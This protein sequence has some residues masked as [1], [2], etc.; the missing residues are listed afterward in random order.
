MNHPADLTARRVR[1][2]TRTIPVMMTMEVDTAKLHHLA[3]WIQPIFQTGNGG[4]LQ[5]ERLTIPSMTETQL[6]MASQS[7]RRNLWRRKW[8]WSGL[9][10]L[11]PNMRTF[12]L[13]CHQALASQIRPPQAREESYIPLHRE[14]IRA[15]RMYLPI[16]ICRLACCAHF[17]TYNSTMKPTYLH[18]HQ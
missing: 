6:A 11:R 7:R 12:A 9:H 2:R 5:L 15:G 4:L 3:V 14:P 8:S 18:D 16:L 17:H 1:A 13:R 10:V